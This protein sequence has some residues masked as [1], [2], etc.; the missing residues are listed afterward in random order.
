MVKC[1]REM[2]AKMRPH[3]I[4]DTLKNRPASMQ[5]GVNIGP[6]TKRHSNY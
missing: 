5:S 1:N 6:T 4:Q 3:D 2:L